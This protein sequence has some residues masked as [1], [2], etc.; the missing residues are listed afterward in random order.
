MEQQ[1]IQVIESIATIQ[2]EA[3]EVLKK[4]PS[5]VDNILLREL[6]QINYEEVDQAIDDYI[7]L[8]TSIKVLP[9]NIKML[10]SYQI[11]V[12]MH[13]L[14]T[15]EEYW[16]KTWPIG[17]RTVWDMLHKAYSRFHPEFDII[18]TNA[19]NPLSIVWK[20]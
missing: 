1:T 5:S 20:N 17:V 12:C 6:L 3:L 16:V 18:D 10:R 14:F 13:I 15:M 7:N 2:L 8:Y 4:N 11:S 19:I 9:A